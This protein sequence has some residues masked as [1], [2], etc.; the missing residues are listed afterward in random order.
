[1]ARPHANSVAIGFLTVVEHPP[2][3]LFGGY[4]VLNAA[5]RPLE[6]HCTAPIQPSRAQQILYG[7]TLEP[8]LYGE[9]IGATLVGKSSPPPWVVLVDQPAAIFVRQQVEVPAALVVREETAEFP[10]QM[11]EWIEFSLGSNHL[12]LPARHSADRE[13]IVE[14]L[15]AIDDLFDLREPFVRIREAIDEAQRTTA[16]AA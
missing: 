5:G 10:V 3:G 14:R 15:A 7:P 11:A 16:K 2:H 1:M 9:Q 6:F 4:L 8:F 12:L 13:T